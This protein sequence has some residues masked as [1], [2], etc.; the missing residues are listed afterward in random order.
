MSKRKAPKSWAEQLADLDDPTPRD[1]DPEDV[2]SASDEA[3]GLS[4][5][6]SDA[7][8]NKAREHYV[9]VG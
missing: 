4:S 1:I 7:E 9:G 5:A 3:N 2:A 8:S 6:G